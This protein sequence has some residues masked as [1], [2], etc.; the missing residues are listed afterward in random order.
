M[1]WATNAS[2][3]SKLVVFDGCCKTATSIA[4]MSNERNTIRQNTIDIKKKA[5]YEVLQEMKELSGD[6]TIQ[7]AVRKGVSKGG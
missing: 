6:K 5:G 2:S 4:I 1:Q 3:L 7:R